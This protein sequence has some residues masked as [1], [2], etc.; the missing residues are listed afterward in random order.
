MRRSAGLLGVIAVLVGIPA[1]VG[2]IA[3]SESGPAPPASTSTALSARATADPFLKLA[4][5]QARDCR[6]NLVG[7]S[8][9]SCT[10]KPRG[11]CEIDVNAGTA[12][13][14]RPG[15]GWTEYLLL[16]SSKTP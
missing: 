6:F 14:D 12:Q 3:R 10:L 15:T 1:A 16:Q 13:C 11:K 7:R 9:I 4:G 5:L 8:S 2:V